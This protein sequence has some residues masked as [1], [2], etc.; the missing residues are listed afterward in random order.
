MSKREFAVIDFESL[1]CFDMRMSLFALLISMWATELL[2]KLPDYPNCGKIDQEELTESVL[3]GKPTAEGEFPWLAA[4]LCHKCAGQTDP[5]GR[6][7][8]GI[9]ISEYFLLTAAHCLYERL[10]KNAR[11]Q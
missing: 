10:E 7:C 11:N 2:A 3:R 8:G 9:L 6:W 1:H 5:H 4:V